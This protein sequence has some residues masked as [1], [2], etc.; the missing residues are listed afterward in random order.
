MLTFFSGCGCTRRI[1][2]GDIL[3]MKH[4]RN[5]SLVKLSPL[6]TGVERT[7]CLNYGTVVTQAL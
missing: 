6:F 2:G 3:K 4:N 5:I 7:P 1:Y